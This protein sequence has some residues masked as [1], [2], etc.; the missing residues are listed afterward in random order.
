M[1]RYDEIII[2]KKFD[3]NNTQKLS[4]KRGIQLIETSAK[5]AENVESAFEAMAKKLIEAK[6]QCGECEL[7]LLFLL[8][9]L[10]CFVLTCFWVQGNAY[11]VLAA[12]GSVQK[13]Y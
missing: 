9:I 10:C 3:E 12:R 6:N 7:L 13:L 1:P 5:N 2:V 4:E 8:M 11:E